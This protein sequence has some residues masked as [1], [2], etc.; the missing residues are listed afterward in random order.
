[1]R[2][3]LRNCRPVWYANLI[4]GAETPV[5]DEQGNETGETAFMYTVPAQIWLNVSEPDGEAEAGSFGGFADYTATIVTSDLMCPLEQG[6]QIWVRTAPPD[7]NDYVVTA[8]APSID[9]V[10][11]TLRRVDV[12]ALPD[13]LIFRAEDG[14]RR[15]SDQTLYRVTSLAHGGYKDAD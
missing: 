3:L 8:R 10:S 12:G 6:A 14:I 5:V 13:R 1:M 11:Y 2:D 9:A 7:A 4:P 15:G